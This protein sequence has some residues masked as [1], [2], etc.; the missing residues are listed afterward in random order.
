MLIGMPSSQMARSVPWS[1]FMPRRKYWWLCPRPLCWVTI[2]PGAA[3]S[4]S[5]VARP[6]ALLSVSP[7]ALFAGCIRRLGFQRARCGDGDGGQDRRRTRAGSEQDRVAFALVPR[8]RRRPGEPRRE[9]A[10]YALKTDSAYCACRS[11]KRRTNAAHNPFRRRRSRRRPRPPYENASLCQPI[12]RRFAISCAASRRGSGLA[13]AARPMASVSRRSPT[14]LYDHETRGLG[15]RL[16]PGAAQASRPAGRDA[17][18]AS[19]S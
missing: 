8:R 15:Q 9:G 7:D 6:A 12:G 14:S 3:S 11:S 18:C 5:P 4:T 16:D 10:L 19:R 2:R 17:T 1:R 13:M